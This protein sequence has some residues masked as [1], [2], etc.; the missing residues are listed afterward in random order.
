MNEDKMK[1]GITTFL[2][3]LGVDLSDQHIEGTPDRVMRA[4]RD[5][6]GAGYD[7]DPIEILTSAGFTEGY[8]N[9]VIVKDI[10]FNSHCSHH[11]VSFWGTAKIGYIPNGKV[12]GL[13][14]LARVLDVY[15]QRLQIQER[16]TDQVAN[17]IWEA[18]EPKGVGVILKAQHMCMTHRGV[19]KPGSITVTS[20]MLGAMKDNQETRNEFLSL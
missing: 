6:F 16:L 15:A 13:S 20:S 11:L 12:T 5:F 2:E 17:A 4:W 14:K 1:S 18:L 3:G 8:D 9:M 19:L 10:P 7:K